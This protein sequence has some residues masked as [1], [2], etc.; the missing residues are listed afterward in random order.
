MAFLSSKKFERLERSIDWSQKQLVFPRKKRMEAV[1]QFM[2]S[3]YAENGSEKIVPVPFLA[4]AV[5]VY[6]RQL[7]PNSPRAMFTADS[8]RLRPV[9]STFELAINK[10]PEEIKLSRTLRK[11]VAEAMF[12]PWGVVKCGLHTVGKALGH[13]YGEPFVDLVTFEDYFVDMSAKNPDEI[14]YEGNDYWIDYESLMESKEIVSGTRDK[15]SP[16]DR[17]YVGPNG[18]DRADSSTTDSTAETY[19]D[20]LWARDV[21]LPDEN[22]LVTY[23]ITSKKVIFER[24]LKGPPR[25]PYHKLSFI[26]VPSESMAL[27]LVSL[28]RDL[29]ELANALFRKLGNQADSQKTVLG[30]DG[31]NEENVNNFQNARDGDGISWTGRKPEQLTAGGIDRNTLAFQL[32][33]RELFSYFANNLDSLG[34]LAA[35]TETIGQDRLISEASTAQLKDMAESVTDVSQ[36]IFTALAYYEWHD[37]VKRRRLEKPIPGTDMAIPIEFGPEMKIGSFDLYDLK[38]DV[39]SMQDDSPG[40]KLQKLDL[41]VNKFVLPLGELATQTGG[42]IQVEKI[43]SLASKYMNFPEAEEIVVF[44][45]NIAQPGSEGGGG[46]KPAHTTREYVRRGSPGQTRQGGSEATQQILLGGEDR[47]GEGS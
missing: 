12:S 13:E 9:A 21:W 40:T 29:H 30:F 5:M 47:G 10:I 24:E 19:K 18:E 31:D 3:H 25:G 1:K 23:G 22:L 27:P 36:G 11:M 44:V 16:D 2:G 43:F 4:L 35:S 26:D 6:L 7:V 39:Y 32:Q 37:P 28:W 33:C 17:T 14:D 8:D 45:D 20:K 46:A 38:I 15:L 41:F 34:G 42:V